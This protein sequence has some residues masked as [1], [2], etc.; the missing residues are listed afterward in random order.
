MY[1]TSMY[2]DRKEKVNILQK[3]YVSISTK[4][5]NYEVPALNKNN[6]VAD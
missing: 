6:D 2:S 1:K 4:E 5:P 3:Y